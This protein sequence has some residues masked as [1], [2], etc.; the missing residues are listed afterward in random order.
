MASE[1]ANKCEGARACFLLV[2]SVQVAILG[3]LG[4]VVVPNSSCW[5]GWLACW[6]ELSP[7]A[8]GTGERV[9]DGCCVWFPG[10]NAA[11]VVASTSV[12][13]PRP[14]PRGERGRGRCWAGD[15]LISSQQDRSDAAGRARVAKPK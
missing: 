3:A 12:R 8:K 11:G 5:G 7:W 1:R 13:A 15:T 10:A 2:V 14:S 9:A 4:A 6:A